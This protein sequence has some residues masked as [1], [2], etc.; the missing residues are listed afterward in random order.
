MTQWFVACL[1][2]KPWMHFQGSFLC[3]F[4]YF[5]TYVIGLDVKYLIFCN[6][7]RNRR[8]IT[9]TFFSVHQMSVPVG[10]LYSEFKK[11]SSNGHPMLLAMGGGAG[12]EPGGSP[13][14]MSEGELGLRQQ[15]WWI[16]SL[17]SNGPNGHGHMDRYTPVKWWAV[18]NF[19][20]VLHYIFTA[21]VAE[22]RPKYET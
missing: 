13:C 2:M 15:G 1:T 14:P 6:H 20:C 21:N 18:I 5:A 8:I 19:H 16:C 10:A 4:G 11:V 12:L 17:R 22:E 7:I 3:D 9:E